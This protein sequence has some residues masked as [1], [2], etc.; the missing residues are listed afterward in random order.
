MNNPSKEAHGAVACF[1]ALR[2]I[3][4]IATA[5]H[6]SHETES[7]EFCYL[8]DQ[9]LIR[10]AL[11]HAAEPLSPFMAGFLSL[12][13]EYLYHSNMSGAPNLYV[14]KPETLMTEEEAKANLAELFSNVLPEK[15]DPTYIK[16]GAPQCQSASNTFH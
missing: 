13:A 9:E 15:S 2:I 12:I 8:R 7:S 16:I 4:R 11:I 14:W 1:E 5:P 6:D 10:S 3:E